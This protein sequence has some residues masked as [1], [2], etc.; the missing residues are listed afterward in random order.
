MRHLVLIALGLLTVACASTS[1]LDRMDMA[2]Q[3]DAISKGRFFHAPTFNV[4]SGLGGDFTLGDT[5]DS[6]DRFMRYELDWLFLFGESGHVEPFGE[7]YI[8]FEDREWSE[9]T[10]KVDVDFWGFGLGTGVMAYAW[11]G[12]R[13]RGFNLAVR[14]YARLGLGFANGTFRDLETAS[15]LG[16]GSIDSAR[17]EGA[18][19]LDFQAVVA[20]RVLAS[21]GVGVVVWGAEDGSASVDTEGG[22]VKEKVGFRGYDTFVRAGIGFTF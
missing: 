16:R 9:G 10:A 8:Y 20:H 19:G 17:F 5:K 11:E 6:W 14:P 1:T 7:G 15:G 3:S 22:T 4:A 12:G 18:I 2:Y 13:Q 21:L